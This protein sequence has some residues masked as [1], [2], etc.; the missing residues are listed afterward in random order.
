MKTKFVPLSNWSIQPNS[1]ELLGNVFQF[2][3]GNS[4]LTEDF[5]YNNQPNSEEE[6]ISVFSGATLEQNSMG[7]I[8]KEARPK[9]R[10]LKISQSPSILVI[11]KGR[12]GKM[13]YVEGISFAA[14]DDVYVITPKI[15]WKDRLSLKWFSY[16]YQEL[17]YNL[18]T[19]KSDNSTFNKEYAE[20]QRVVIP[21]F[22]DQLA[23]INKK[24]ILEELS[25]RILKLIMSIRYIISNTKMSLST[26][27]NVLLGSIFQFKGGYSGL[28][29]DFIYNNQPNSEEEKI[30]VFSGATLEQNS[31]GF[32]SKEAMF[33]NKKLRIFNGDFILVSRNGFKAGTMTY[34]KDSKFAINDHAYVMGLRKEWVDKI[35]LRWFA[36]QY[37]ELFFNLVTSKTDNATFNKEYAEKQWIM[38]PDKKIQDNIGKKLIEMNDLLDALDKIDKQIDKIKRFEIV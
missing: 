31:M 10:K 24:K 28:T 20:K 5:I 36:Y 11:R 7:F 17:F 4:G 15:I 2:E 8:S 3:G 30:S 35:N 12:A 38:V 1:T 21:E 29:E 6:K 33:G 23:Q 27:E 16:Q 14:N 18:V 37:Q 22:T 26:N 34:L 19:S 9:G 25:A 32:I 13:I